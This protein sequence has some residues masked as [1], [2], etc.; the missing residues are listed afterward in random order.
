M[1]VQTGGVIASHILTVFQFRIEDL[2][3]QP[4]WWDEVEKREQENNKRLKK[5]GL[6]ISFGNNSF[7]Y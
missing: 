3:R 5:N 1:Q 2:Y 7:L 6:F 4:S